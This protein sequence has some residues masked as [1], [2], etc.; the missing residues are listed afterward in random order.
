MVIRVVRKLEK[1]RFH[2]KLARRFS[3][4]TVFPYCEAVNIAVPIKTESK[5]LGLISKDQLKSN[6]RV[7]IAR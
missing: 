1:I 6:S 4:E 2:F 3:H 5:G 7:I